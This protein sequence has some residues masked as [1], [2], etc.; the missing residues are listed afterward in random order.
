MNAKN[1]SGAA[2]EK[3]L[4]A[5]LRELLDGISWLGDWTVQNHPT[6]RDKGFDFIVNIPRPN[7]GKAELWVQCKADPRPSLFP[8]AFVASEAKHPPALVLAAPLVSPRMAEV[9]KENGWGWFDLA[10]NHRLDVPGLLHLQHTGNEAVHKRQRPAANLST[11][12]A[13]RVICALLLPDHAGMRWTQREMQKHCQ[14]SVSL[15]LVNKVVRHL[16]DEAFIERAEDGGFRLREPLKLLFVWRDAYRFDR[17]E[18]RGY[19]TL[20]QGKKLRDALAG[21]GLE[22]GGFAAYAAFS[23]AEFQAPHVRQPKTWLYVREPEV[24]KLE[25][26]VEAKRVDSGEN[27]VVLIPDDDGVFYSG[28]GVTMGDNRMSCT[29]AVQTYVDLY[30]CGGRGEE[31]AEALLNQRLKPE[32]K[33][34]GL[35]V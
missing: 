19:F 20:L 13:G 32:W 31:A 33:L 23:A 4:V 28:D 2:L 1:L 21:L 11:P 25:E 12:E 26:L 35:N 3:A 29:N 24:S 16:R 5:K 7:G 34:R 6:I 10:G 17:H 14:P 30:H 22:T 15:G 8:Y 9:C 27:L 18:R